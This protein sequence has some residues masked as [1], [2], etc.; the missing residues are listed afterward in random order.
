MVGRNHTAI[1]SRDFL[2]SDYFL[3]GARESSLVG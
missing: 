1:L 3:H 2:V